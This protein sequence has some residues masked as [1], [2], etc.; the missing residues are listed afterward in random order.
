MD[1][2]N[3]QEKQT[4]EIMKSLFYIND[5]RKASNDPNSIV[6]RFYLKTEKK[7][8]P[9]G[10]G[11]KCTISE[12]DQ[13]NQRVRR[14]NNEYRKYNKRLSFIQDEITKIEE[15]RNVEANDIDMIVEASIKGIETSQVINETE[16]LKM[17][18]AKRLDFLISTNK[19]K[20]TIFT[21]QSF[22]KK[23]ESYE[24][25]SGSI[26]TLD[27]LVDNIDVVQENLL[28]W[29]RNVE[30]NKDSSISGF[31]NKLNAA[32]NYYNKINKKNIPVF[33]QKDNEYKH[34]KKEI[35]Y[36]T[37]EELTNLYQF[38]YQPTE[39]MMN[40]KRPNEKNMKFLKYFLFRCF[41]GMRV[42][43]M[44]NDNINPKKV[45]PFTKDLEI[46]SGLVNNNLTYN[47]YASK[48]NKIVSVPYMGSY[49]Y[50]IA[51]SLDW[52]FPDL[53]IYSDYVC[54]IRDEAKA[55]G[56]VLKK[57]YGDKIR[58]IEQVIKG[59]YVYKDLSDSIT[60]HT[61]RKTFA[62]L[63]YSDNKDIVQVMHCLGHSTIEM[64]MRYM[65][66]KRDIKSLES[67]R[68]NLK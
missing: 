50:D 44:N 60:T 34:D 61:A 31:F 29:C 15:K 39:S 35:I 66:I 51:R 7:Y 21:Y 11:I 9:K 53:S 17:A 54:Y 32:I 27:S 64:T 8:K 10:L 12:W 36:L 48:N 37:I 4:K 65:G 6:L 43:E 55:V 25:Y 20:G 1:W 5:K 18:L 40:I 52:E 26:I 38:V 14:S 56:N 2:I 24:R 46:E 41:C 47:Y 58:K 62:Y 67:F 16:N 23:I 28:K 22:I 19:A 3:Q 42:N 63:I 33:T 49:L 45:D 13:E 30:N 59:R 57:I 68:L